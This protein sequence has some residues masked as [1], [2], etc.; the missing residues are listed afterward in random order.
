MINTKKAIFVIAIIFFANSINAQSN[1]S[2]QLNSGISDISSSVSGFSGLLQLNY[3]LNS[4]L[5]IYLYSGYSSVD[6]QT[7]N[8][9]IHHDLNLSNS[10]N[11]S[12][13]IMGDNNIIPIYFGGSLDLFENEWITTFANLEMGYSY[14]SFSTYE[15]MLPINS[16]AGDVIRY[17]PDRSTREKHSENLF[18]TG[19]GV[20]ASHQITKGLEV[21]LTLKLNTNT[22]FDGMKMFSRPSTYTSLLAGLNYRL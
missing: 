10:R 12:G 9:L 13:S 1:F 7:N 5:D 14:L 21:L 19:I 8:R 3:S 17:R 6:R 18:G 20:G 4:D 2:I 16:D 15:R 11:H 22:N